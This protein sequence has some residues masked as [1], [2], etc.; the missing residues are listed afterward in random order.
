MCFIRFFAG[1]AFAAGLAMIMYGGHHEVTLAIVIGAFQVILAVLALIKTAS[2]ADLIGELQRELKMLGLAFMLVLL[3]L[4]QPAAAISRSGNAPWCL[5]DDWSMLCF[6]Y[7]RK[8][9]EAAAESYSSR[10]T[11]VPNT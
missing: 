3:G 7:S 9:C 11:C 2:R 4:P 10:Y 8:S 5:F 1:F 6:Y